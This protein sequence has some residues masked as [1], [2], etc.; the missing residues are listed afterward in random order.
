[1]LIVRTSFLPGIAT[2]SAHVSSVSIYAP[3]CSSFVRVLRHLCALACPTMTD[4]TDFEQHL[5]SVS[6]RS[7]R[8]VAVGDWA[9]VLL[10]RDTVRVTN[11]TYAFV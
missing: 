9:S 2:A 4:Y 6:G 10:V 1:M 8:S 11:S 5:K 3:A 7:R